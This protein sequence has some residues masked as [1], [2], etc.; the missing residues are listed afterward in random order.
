MNSSDASR[1]QCR[2]VCVA[3]RDGFTRAVVAVHAAH[4]RRGATG[5]GGVDPTRAGELL[6]PRFARRAGAVA[7]TSAPLHHSSTPAL[8]HSTTPLLHSHRTLLQH[9]HPAPV[10]ASLPPI[11][12][13]PLVSVTTASTPVAVVA[14]PRPPS[15]QLRGPR[16]AHSRGPRPSQGCS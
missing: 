16:G 1:A 11:F 5:R 15:H 8:H 4:G 13:S 7:A 3:E 9:S 2:R 14:V 6:L 10:L 12:P